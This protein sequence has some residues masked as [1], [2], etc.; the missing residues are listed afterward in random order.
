M[1]DGNKSRKDI[2][3]ER[4]VKNIINQAIIVTTNALGYL[5]LAFLFPEEYIGI[6]SFEMRNHYY[7]KIIGEIKRRY[8]TVQEPPMTEA[9]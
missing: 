8:K 3:D 9:K 6:P 1:L 7:A 2:G 4:Q 5:G